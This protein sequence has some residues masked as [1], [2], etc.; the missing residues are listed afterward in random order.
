MLSVLLKVRDY[1]WG[2]EENLETTENGRNATGNLYSDHQAANQAGNSSS[3]GV[4][5][6]QLNKNFHGT[7]TKLYDGCGVID[8]D[9][10]FTFGVILGGI[11]PQVG[12]E[13]HV[14]ASRTAE[15]SGWQATR[16]QLVS[17]S[18]DHT[19]D[20]GVYTE[21]ENF[22]GLITNL[23][24]DVVTV[25]DSV[26]FPLSCLRSGYVAHKGDWVKLFLSRRAD[27]LARVE[28]AMP[29]RERSFTG[30]V[31][32]VAP[33]YGFID[34]EVY[35]SFRIC[36]RYYRPHKGDLVRLTAV[37]SQQGR[38]NWRAVKVE[39]KLNSA[40]LRFKDFCSFH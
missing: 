24:T 39:P 10:Y 22:I 29:V 23:T 3:S 11:R 12:D 20:G 32:S 34:D 21:K 36:S 35:F 17:D 30:T 1:V 7:I 33:G 2:G 14:E 27:G 37:E 26:D 38:A 15:T 8:N 25:D 19:N 18:W 28:G 5:A 13:V 9:V 6:Q 4:L 40:S 16:V 31:S